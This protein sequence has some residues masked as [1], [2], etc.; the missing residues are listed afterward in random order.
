MVA[1]KISRL[2]M[3]PTSVVANYGSGC[4]SEDLLQSYPTVSGKFD[5]CR[6]LAAINS[7]YGSSGD[8][9]LDPVGDLSNTEPCDSCLLDYIDILAAH[10]GCESSSTSA[11]NCGDLEAN[12]DSY[13]RMCTG[14]GPRW[15]IMVLVSVLVI[16]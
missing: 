7:C 11:S 12:A 8:S 5:D 1:L 4:I 16:F 3:I 6:G 13:F 14:L 2:T 9:P 15:I 10:T